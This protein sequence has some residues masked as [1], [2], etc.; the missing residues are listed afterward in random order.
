AEALLAIIDDILDISKIE[1]GKLPLEAVG[2]GLRDTCGAALRVLAPRAAA[3]GL[4]LALDV[5]ADVPDRLIGDPGRLRQV[6]LNLVGNAIKFT[7][8][9]EIVVA[10]RLVDRSPLDAALDVAVRDTGL[11]I[12]ADKL[13]TIFDA[14]SQADE[15]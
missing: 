15:S 4:E 12:P 10:V 7:E 11:G 5:P 8:R 2:F 1:A 9:G 13:G 6:L 3:K 14:F